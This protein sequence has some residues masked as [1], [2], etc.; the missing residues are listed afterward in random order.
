MSK[1]EQNDDRNTLVKN[2]FKLIGILLATIICVVLIRNYYHNYNENNINTSIIGQTL[3]HGITADELNNYIN[4]N[5]N[6]VL[7][8]TKASDE[9]CRKLEEKIDDS[10]ED[11]KLKNSIIYLDMN[12]M[13]KSE[14]DNFFDN[15]NKK[16]SKETKVNSYPVIVK[17]EDGKVINVAGKTSNGNLTVKEF[18]DFIDDN[19]V[20]SAE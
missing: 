8:I 10:I 12:D 7:Y 17:F 9:Y 14:I 15:F 5:S 1:R 11:K 18:N 19:G 20:V 16:Y 6:T 3:T 2:Y 4:E 13:S